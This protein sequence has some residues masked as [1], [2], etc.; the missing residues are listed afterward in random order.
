DSTCNCA[1]HC[2]RCDGGY[3]S[4]AKMPR[5]FQQCRIKILSSVRNKVHHHHQED[6]IKEQFPMRGNRTPKLAPG[7][8]F[9]LL[10]D[11]RLFHVQPNINGEQRRESP[12]EEH[13]S[14]APPRKNEEITTGS[15]EVTCRI[16]FLQ[17]T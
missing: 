7:F 3:F 9:S 8:V 14:P 10:P 1:N 12:D 11:L 6:E 2:E 16:S 4:R 13:R 17:Q 15:Q 5:T